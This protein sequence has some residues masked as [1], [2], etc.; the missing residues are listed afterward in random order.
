MAP[1]IR[2]CCLLMTGALVATL[3]PAVLP[4]FLDAF[5]YRSLASLA[6]SL[7]H[8]SFARARPVSRL[9]EL[10]LEILE[11]VLSY[12]HADDVSRIAL[13]SPRLAY[14]T[15]RYRWTKLSIRPGEAYYNLREWSLQSAMAGTQSLRSLQVIIPGLDVTVPIPNDLRQAFSDSVREL[16]FPPRWTPETVAFLTVVAGLTPH[17]IR[18][19]V[20]GSSSNED[21]WWS[22]LQRI[23]V[24][25]TMNPILARARV[26]R[27]VNATKEGLHFVL[28]KKL[29]D[30]TAHLSDFVDAI[31]IKQT[32]TSSEWHSG[33]DW[34]DLGW[35]A[36]AE[37]KVEVD[38]R[39]KTS[40]LHVDLTGSI[41][42]LLYHL[43]FPSLTVLVFE[44]GHMRER[45]WDVVSRLLKDC[46]PTLRE[47]AFLA[48]THTNLATWAYYSI[49]ALPSLQVV[50]AHWKVI[51][52]L[53]DLRA[54][55]RP[56]AVEVF[57]EDYFATIATA[58]EMKTAREFL[59]SGHWHRITFLETA[60]LRN[61]DNKDLRSRRRAHLM[62]A[63]QEHDIHFI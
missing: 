6:Q 1:Y 44:I 38:M 24:P 14:L 53:P 23:W 22:T 39:V 20:I 33:E 49:D 45:E 9:E 10:P 28:L 41:S 36:V 60:F 34:S 35:G 31:E 5:P 42:H 50:R 51:A 27:F 18:T 12:C 16:V 26:L 3:V 62:D 8:G 19:L 47:L 37:P 7:R 52:Y 46:A 13:T 4:F 40:S 2:D 17:S 15:R 30:N 21:K 63:L 56:G 59:C 48:G 58:G 55:T 11:Q 61:P 43:H 29:R 32:S 25:S 54:W 57:V